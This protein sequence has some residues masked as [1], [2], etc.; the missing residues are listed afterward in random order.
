MSS[1]GSIRPYGWRIN[2]GCCRN[3]DFQEIPVCPEM[4]SRDGNNLKEIEEGK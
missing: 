3:N 1:Y 4:F 2:Y